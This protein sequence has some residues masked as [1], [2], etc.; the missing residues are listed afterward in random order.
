MEIT[1]SYSQSLTNILDERPIKIHLNLTVG[2]Y[3]PTSS[4]TCHIYYIH[5]LILRTTLDMM[6]TIIA[7]FTNDKVETQ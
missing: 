7:P 1:K 2:H 6:G 4:I 5:D 3:T